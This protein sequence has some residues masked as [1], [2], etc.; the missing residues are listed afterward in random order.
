[1]EIVIGIVGLLLDLVAVSA[2]LRVA[3]VHVEPPASRESSSSRKRAAR[4]LERADGSVW[5]FGQTR[6]TFAFVSLMIENVVSGHCWTYPIEEGAQSVM[7][8]HSTFLFINNDKA[9]QQ[10]G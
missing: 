9:E 10:G 1:M 4:P 6:K 8:T 5:F 2:L 7:Q 3:C